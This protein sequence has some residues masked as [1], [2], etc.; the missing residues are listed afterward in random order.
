[1]P[2]LPIQAL[3]VFPSLSF[4]HRFPACTTT[5]AAGGAAVSGDVCTVPT[6]LGDR[7]KPLRTSAFSRKDDLALRASI[8]RP[9]KI[10]RARPSATS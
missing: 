7:Y 4:V 1:M 9:K 6:Y 5:R 8:R 2:I 10:D 3:A